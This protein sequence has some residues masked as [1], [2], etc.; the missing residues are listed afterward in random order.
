MLFKRHELEE[1]YL[2][3][4][5]MVQ[6]GVLPDEHGR[7]KLLLKQIVEI[8]DENSNNLEKKSWDLESKVMSGDETIRLLTKKSVGPGEFSSFKKSMHK[9]NAEY[10]EPSGKSLLVGL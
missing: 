5:K 10:Q 3:L 8:I 9:V 1:A 6:A 7:L 2:D 4:D